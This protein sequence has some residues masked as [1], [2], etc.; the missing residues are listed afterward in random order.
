MEC[1]KNI[2]G[3]TNTDCLCVTDY[4]E[5]GELEQ[6]RLS[7]SGLY[8]DGNLEGGIS[9]QDIK[10]LDHCGEYFRLAKKAIKTAED[11]FEADIKMGIGAKYKTKKPRFMGEIGRMTYTRIIDAKP[12]RNYIKIASQATGHAVLNINT[13]RM[14]IVSERPEVPVRVWVQRGENAELEQVAEGVVQPAVNKFKSVEWPQ[15]LTLPKMPLAA[16]NKLYSYFVEWEAVEG[17]KYI[18]NSL[19][20]GCSG[21][22]AY[23]GYVNVFGGVAESMSETM[24]GKEKGQAYGINIDTEI[25]CELGSLVC[26][27]YDADEALSLAAAYGVL[28]KAGEMLI[29]YVLESP[30]INRFTMM[31]REYLWG[32]RT[33]FRARYNEYIAY[34]VQEID[35]TA[36]DCFICRSGNK[37]K[38]TNLFG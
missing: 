30:E 1:L 14:N 33:H 20:C 16:G 35:V 36:N 5:P 22:D 34:M 37:M 9:M 10:L 15:G 23:D 6:I 27:G 21:G 4:L 28:F 13:I 19:S 8:L 18:D 7:R 3:V 31:N 32:K 29:E 17:D 25:R 2:I 12:G 24:A 38:V 26:E 11:A